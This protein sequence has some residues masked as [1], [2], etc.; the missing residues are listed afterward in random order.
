M[1]HTPFANPRHSLIILAACAGMAAAAILTLD[2][3]VA[4]WF[5]AEY[6]AGLAW[7]RPFF[8]LLDTLGDSAYTL[9]PTGVA[10]LVIGLLRWAGRARGAW[11]QPMVARVGYVF[12]TVAVSGLVVNLLKGVFGRARPRMLFADGT[13]GFDGFIFDSDYAAFPSGH[14]TTAFALAG[15]LAVLFPRWRWLALPVAALVGVARVVMGSHYPADVLMGA[16][17]GLAF[18]V[19]VREVFL[20]RGWWMQCLEGASSSTETASNPLNAGRHHTP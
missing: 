17:V 18:A 14:T 19:G 15:C 7:Y 5:E 6:Q 4:R 11:M 8:D 9:W 12:L 16:G 1:L 13:Y 10:L 2:R 3:P 20:R